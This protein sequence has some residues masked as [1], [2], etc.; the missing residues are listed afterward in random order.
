MLYC[1]VFPAG[2]LSVLHRLLVKWFE[3]CHRVVLF[4]QFTCDAVSCCAVLCCAVFPPGKLSVLHRLLV[5]LHERGH[6]V[7][8]FS[9]FTM[10][11]GIL[12]DYL[13]LA[14]FE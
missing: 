12:E 7:V 4:S 5:K 14:G 9:Q 1:N 3:C 2:K 13:S 6:R 8:L 11:L 10:M